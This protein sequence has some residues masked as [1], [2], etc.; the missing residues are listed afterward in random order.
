VGVGAC[1]ASHNL[2]PMGYTTPSTA[3]AA[4]A[5]LGSSATQAPHAAPQ[6]A[7]HCVLGLDGGGNGTRWCL[8]RWD[9]AVVAQGLAPVLPSLAPLSEAAPT[10]GSGPSPKKTEALDAARAPTLSALDGVLAQLA[11]ALPAMPH[12]VL[13]GLT[14]FDPL[15]MPVLRP[16]LAAAF[17]VPERRAIAV[18][19]IELLCT[20]AFAP[21]EGVLVYAGTGSIAAH[22]RADGSLQRAGGRGVVIDDAGSGHWIATQALRCV[23]RMEDQEPGSAQRS[24]LAQALFTRLGGSDW[25]STRHWVAQATR[26]QMGQLAL[27][28][29]AAAPS[30]PLALDLLT[31]AGRELAR[32]A[33]AL[34]LRE[35]PQ[36]VA[37]AGRVFALHP[38]LQR[39]FTVELPLGVPVRLL[40]EAPH[41]GAA[42]LARER[43][44][45]NES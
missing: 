25:A 34:L 29:A 40:D 24:P 1:G 22:L 35:G 27:Q 4:A 41:H 3:A 44:L 8:M 33:A 7:D 31:A 30:D 6:I 37:L 45:Q 21:G 16:R 39:S 18:S 20:M 23:W 26:G 42:R 12:T 11:Q 9:G 13:A 19:D 17:G 10:A 5:G 15:V 43:S 38:E 2:G 36:P 14:G 28:V 32:L